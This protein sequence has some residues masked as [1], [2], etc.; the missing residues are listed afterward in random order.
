MPP[1]IVNKQ[2]YIPFYSDIWSLGILLYTMLFG[3]FPFESKKES[4]LFA[5]INKAKLNFP[6]DIEVSGEVKNLL[7]KIIV[8]KPNKRSSLEDILNDPW[9][10]NSS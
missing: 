1:E 4:E 9:I 6:N 2:K 3:T 10:K 7:F 8:I 5:L